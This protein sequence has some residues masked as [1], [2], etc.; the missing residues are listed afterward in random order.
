MTLKLDWN[1]ENIIIIKCSEKTE[2]EKPIKPWSS[3][4]KAKLC[5]TTVAVQ[6]KRN[7]KYKSLAMHV[8]KHKR[9]FLFRIKWNEVKTGKIATTKMTTITTYDDDVYT[10]E[11]HSNKFMTTSQI[12]KLCHNIHSRHSILY[13]LW[14]DGW[15]FF[16]VVTQ[17]LTSLKRVKRQRKQNTE[18]NA[19]NF[20][21]IEK[22]LL[23]EKCLYFI[24]SFIVS[25]NEHRSCGF[26]RKKD[27][28][29]SKSKWNCSYDF[30]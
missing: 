17:C 6:K 25:S 12:S 4:N 14:L 5:W 1:T 26:H 7:P 30:S 13:C 2:I 19:I 21:E 10:N 8:K 22:N 20:N 15:V 3:R 29:I 28:R 11:E 18:I 16:V 23:N 27:L 24:Q 9:Y